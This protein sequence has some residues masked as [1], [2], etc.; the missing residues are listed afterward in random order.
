MN[1]LAE[2][3]TGIV[4]PAAVTAAALLTGLLSWL[5]LYHMPQQ[6]KMFLTMIDR[7]LAEIEKQRAEARLDRERIV[8]ALEQ[9]TRAVRE[10]GKGKS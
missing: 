8:G 2:Q 10:N 4:G 9:L 7:F 1:P 5:L 6:N 3:G